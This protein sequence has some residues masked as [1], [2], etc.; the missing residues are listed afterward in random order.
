M[1]III[2]LSK[3]QN[4]NFANLVVMV[5]LA[6]FE[7]WESL[8]RPSYYHHFQNERDKIVEKQSSSFNVNNLLISDYSIKFKRRT[9]LL[10]CQTSLDCIWHL[11]VCIY[12]THTQRNLINDITFDTRNLQSHCHQGALIVFRGLVCLTQRTSTYSRTRFQSIA[13]LRIIRKLLLSM[14]NLL[15]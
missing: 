12:Y 15:R 5:H 10:R 6:C 4:D 7:K 3:C 1:M 11:C 9:L 13:S 14:Q 2:Y 8:C